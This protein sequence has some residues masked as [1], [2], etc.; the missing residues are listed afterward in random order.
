MR[1]IVPLLLFALLAG[2]DRPAPPGPPVDVTPPSGNARFTDGEGRDRT[3]FRPIGTLQYGER[4]EDV[5][6]PAEALIGYEFAGG[7]GDAPELILDVAGG[8]TASMA[9]Y[10]P[11]GDNG[12]WDRPLAAVDGRGVLRLAGVTLPADGHYFVL[13]RRLDGRAVGFALQL[14]C[15]G[16]A[17]PPCAEVDACDLF[18]DRG[19]AAGED[20]CRVCGCDEL[21]CAGD[22]DCL[23]GEVCREGQCRPA[24]GCDEQCLGEPAAPVCGAD[25][26]TYPNAC[27]AMCR[28]VAV[29]GEGRCVEPECGDDS[30]CVAPQRCIEGRCR[31]D[32]PPVNDP[33]CGASGVTHSNLC[34]L[35]CAG[36]RFAYRGPCDRV[37]PTGACGDGMPCGDGQVC[38][39]GS[40]EAEGRCATT[41]PVRE[42]GACGRRSVCADV[43]FGERGAC[44]PGCAP[45]RLACPE[46]L[47]CLP[48]RRGRPAC[49]PC[50]CEG[51]AG[52]PVCVDGR[53]EFPSACVARCAGVP[54]ERLQAGGC[55]GPL[56][57]PEP[58]PPADCSLC[59]DAWAPVCADGVLFS[60]GC[61]ATC[62]RDAPVMLERAEQC[63]A[64]SP[65]V[66]CRDDAECG[67]EACGRW[68]CGAGEGGEGC[69]PL[70]EDARCFVELGQC[71]CVEGSCGYRAA[72]GDAQLAACLDRAR[73]P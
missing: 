20:G 41:C 38:V 17:P 44:L 62:G 27:V 22:E 54:E 48:D 59:R 49:F 55:D 14:S 12:L 4:V 24:P 15:P 40:D 35:E 8:A 43:G 39:G 1:S 60:N 72:R 37:P 16:C 53:V 9:L 69:P 46:G 5:L 61:D 57:D 18:C 70:A 36:D 3:A 6:A 67:A 30:E 7:G 29:V 25:G 45:D 64:V 68:A 50:A 71:G 33:V 52:G 19:Y 63:F 47:S 32:C 13:L 34:V 51:D 2:C 42:P 58:A 66:A 23:G 73:M 10:G 65:R 11:R 26:S 21:L 56:P 28:G 31:C